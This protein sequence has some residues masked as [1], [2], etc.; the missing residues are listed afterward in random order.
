[1]QMLDLAN[2]GPG[3]YSGK[4]IIIDGCMYEIGPE[5]GSGYSKI[6]HVLKNVQSGLNLNAIAIRRAG[7]ATKDGFNREFAS[8][9]M[10]HSLGIADIVPNIMRLIQRH[11]T[12]RE[13]YL[14]H[15]VPA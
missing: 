8:K 5:L 12:F 9:I 3:E 11:D 4:G 7:A 15:S 6:V 14:S 2:D 1:M 13:I 10:A